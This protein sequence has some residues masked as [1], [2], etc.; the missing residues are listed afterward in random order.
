[1]VINKDTLEY[2]KKVSAVIVNSENSILLVQLNVYDDNQWNVPGG[3]IEKDESPEEAL[4]RELREE[5]GTD[6]FEI[7]ERS[8]IINKYDFPDNL[9]ETIIKEGKNFRGQEQ[10]QFV[11]RFTGEDPDIVIQEDE[12]RRYKWVTVSELQSHLIF[13]GQCENVIDV[14]NASSLGVI[15]L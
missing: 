13:A 7:L 5:L 15:K 12:V 1:M 11:V 14:L 3:G 2:R 4:H 9:I 10:I 6:K 8:E